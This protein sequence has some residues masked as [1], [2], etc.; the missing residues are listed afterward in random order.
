MACECMYIFDNTEYRRNMA[1]YKE[2]EDIICRVKGYLEPL[3][4]YKAKKMNV[5]QKFNTEDEEYLPIYKKD[6]LLWV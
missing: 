2:L 6:L 3:S 5:F 1:K 4:L